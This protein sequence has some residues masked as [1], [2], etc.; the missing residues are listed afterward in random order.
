MAANSLTGYSAS[1]GFGG[2]SAENEAYD[3][4]YSYDPNGNLLTLQRYDKEGSISHDYNYTYF[5]GTNRLQKVLDEY[6]P[7][8]PESKTYNTNPLVPDGEKYKYITLDS[9]AVVTAGS[10]VDLEATQRIVLKPGTVIESGA[11]FTA[12]LASPDTI[13][14]PPEGQYLYDEIGNLARD[15]AEGVSITWTPYGKVRSV[16]KDNG[17]VI[18]FAYDAAGNRVE[19][20]VITSDTTM[21]THYI[22]DASGNV[23]ATYTNTELKEQPIYGSSR[24]GLYRGGA[25]EG[26]EKL[27]L[28][29][30]ELTNHLGNVLAV[31]TDNINID[32][33]VVT[34]SVASVSDY[35]PFGLSMEGRTYSSDIYRYG[36]NGK[37]DDRELGD[38]QDYGMRMYMKKIGRFPTVD[39][40]TAK[41]PMLTPYQFAS[42]TPIRAIDLDGLEA[43]TFQFELRAIGGANAISVTSSFT[44]GLMAVRNSHGQIGFSSFITPTLGG[45]AGQ[46]LSAGFSGSFYPTVTDPNQLSGLGVNFGAFAGAG[47]PVVSG[48]VEG[49]FAINLTDGSVKGGGTLAPGFS[50]VAIGGGVFGEL[51]YTHILKTVTSEEFFKNPFVLF[52]AETDLEKLGLSSDNL[53]SIGRQL[54]DQVRNDVI[55]KELERLENRLREVQEAPRSRAKPSQLRSIRNEMSELKE[56]QSTLSDLPSVE[57]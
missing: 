50:G 9:G 1:A 44:I 3:A 27:G 13:V 6:I 52:G 51:S 7:P 5:A 28:K 32:D 34:A 40:L 16:T 19:K 15:N 46:G 42:N 4:R 47:L 23:M 8:V 31:V 10:A 21:T 20:E 43:A 45:G 22:R 36:F 55:P 18:N 11:S 29:Y 25:E 33:A 30:Y 2:R 37:E 54:I 35:Y 39:P 53:E 24:L 57:E 38:W 48:G 56:I 41:F 14:I 12:S 17:D 26:K 49:N